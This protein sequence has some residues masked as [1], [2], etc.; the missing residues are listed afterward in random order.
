MEATCHEC[1]YGIIHRC[2]WEEDDTSHEVNAEVPGFKKED[3]QL[4]FSENGHMS[5]TAERREERTKKR[6]DQ[7]EFEGERHSQDPM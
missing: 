5:I 1:A 2:R 4:S 7:G 6:E 3:I